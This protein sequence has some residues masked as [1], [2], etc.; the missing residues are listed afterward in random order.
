MAQTQW[1]D[2]SSGDYVAAALAEIN[3]E[4]RELLWLTYVEELRVEDIGLAFGLSE[5]A[6][7]SRLTRARRALKRKL[8]G[9]KS[10]VSK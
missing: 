3:P 8:R 10:N 7:E 5:H 1:V 9:E 6:V 2:T 4:Y